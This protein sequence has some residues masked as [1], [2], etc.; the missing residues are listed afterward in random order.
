[1][2]FQSSI[3]FTFEGL[4]SGGKYIPKGIATTAELHFKVQ[5]SSVHLGNDV[6]TYLS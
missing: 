3:W 2:E 4:R 1:M 6:N 5:F